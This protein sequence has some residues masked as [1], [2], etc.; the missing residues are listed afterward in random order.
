MYNFSIDIDLI[1]TKIEGRCKNMAVYKSKKSTKDG[2]QYFFRIKYK[3]ILG[4]S[5]DYTSQKYKT[6][7]E[8]V[9]EE[10]RYRIKVGESKITT[11]NVT[12]KQAYEEYMNS[13]REK[14][15]KQ[16]AIKTDELYKHIE[17]YENIKINSIDYAK[18]NKIQNDLANKTIIGIKRKNKI[19]ALLKTIIKSSNK[20][21]NTSMEAIKFIEG[22]KDT[23]YSKKEMLFFTY[24]EY[25]KFDS[26][27]DSHIWHTF[28]EMLYFIGLRQGECQALTWEDI[29]FA[30]EEL[31]I[32]KTLSTKIK[33]QEW[34][35]STPKTKN[36]IRTLPLPKMILD[37]LKSLKSEVMNYTDYQN[38]WFIFGNT[39]PLRENNIAKH[40]NKY[41][42]LANVK[43]IRIHDFRHSCASFL[44]NQGASI[45]LVSKYLGHSKVSITLDIY[46]HFYESELKNIVERINNL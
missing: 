14:V 27:I 34:I 36:S 4:V 30:K 37:D 44:I 5:H 18:I 33:G 7:K 2:R 42:K 23:D 25:K 1:Q 11:S 29:S 40:K 9:N 19:L 26:V 22:F 8:A 43:Q 35:I 41:C 38:S 16:T 10:A 45:P 28:F 39:T 6:Q 12:I 17:P 20:Y 46:S 3:D 31:N 32:T 15:K 13:H 24:D 21:F